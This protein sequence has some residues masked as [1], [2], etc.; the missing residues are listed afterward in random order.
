MAVVSKHVK[1][2]NC[3]NESKGFIGLDSISIPFKF[4]LSPIQDIREIGSFASGQARS[5]IRKSFP[6][7]NLNFSKTLVASQEDKDT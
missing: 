4:N 3:D 5:K 6:K 2:T 7:E 1:I